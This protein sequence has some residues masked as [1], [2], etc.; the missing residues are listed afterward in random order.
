MRSHCI[1]NTTSKLCKGEKQFGVVLHVHC[2]C[3][4]PCVRVC[5]LLPFRNGDEEMENR[6]T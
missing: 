3:V 4:C 5:L 6:K 2:V 1:T